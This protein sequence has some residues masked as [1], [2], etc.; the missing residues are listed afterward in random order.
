[1]SAAP[2]R[3]VIYSFGGSSVADA[4]GMRRA[5]DLVAGGP[6]ALVVVVSALLGVTD[7]LA[8]L[9][10]GR[11]GREERLSLLR[12]R[13]LA[14]LGE[15]EL[16]MAEAAE[17]V[18]SVEARLD[19][20]E[21]LIPRVGSPAPPSAH[22][23]ILST[24]EDLSALL[25]AG[26]IRASG[27]EASVVDARSVVRTDARFGAGVP[28]GDALPGL[29][30]RHLA[31]AMAGGAVPVVQGSV[32]ATASGVTTTL[33]RGGGDLTAALL[34]G[35]LE[36]E[37]IHLWTEA[38]GVLTGAP[39]SVDDPRPLGEIDFEEAVELA[40]AAPEV[41]HPMAVAWAA[42]G[43][44]PLR[45]RHISHPDQPGTLV[46][47][48]VHRGTG[49]AAVSSRP[50]VSLIEVR[51]RPCALPYGFLGRVFDV[52]GRHRVEVDLVATSHASTSF[53]VDG[54]VEL[55]AVAADLAPFAEVET[56]DGLTTVTVVGEG[57]LAEPGIDALVFWAVERTPVHLISQASD[58]SLS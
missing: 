32:G 41:M 49:I 11:S 46:S 17:L 6:P 45:V 3:P 53:T 58:V 31:P 30:L 23:A 8:A 24:G 16:H 42:A 50:G 21:R 40:W 57:L 43:D 9:A 1:M 56:R 18:S 55:D 28:D 35:A 7:E 52:L 54:S 13:H 2:P 20:L 5:A 44:V 34:G 4:K 15:L 29:A 37:V 51:T 12:D 27:R 26:A 10:A 19:A 33:G 38:S 25:L 48:N 22:D 14:L 47:G 36:A 39:D